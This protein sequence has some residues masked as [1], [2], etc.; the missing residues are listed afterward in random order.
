MNYTNLPNRVNISQ[1]VNNIKDTLGWKNDLY[2]MYIFDV[3]SNPDWSG[4]MDELRKTLHK[5]INN[6]IDICDK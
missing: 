4:L 5:K 2:N 1:S 6:I 3:D